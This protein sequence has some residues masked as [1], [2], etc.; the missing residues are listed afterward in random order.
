MGVPG[1]F[2]EQVSSPRTDMI[3]LKGGFHKWALAAVGR[4][5]YVF[6]LSLIVVNQGV[7]SLYE[8]QMGCL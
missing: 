5:R 4:R 3:S 1:C 8:I 2:L 7:F 6:D